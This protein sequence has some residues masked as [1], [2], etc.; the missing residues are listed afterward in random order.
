MRKNLTLEDLGDLLDL[1][2][3]AIL[4]THRKD[5]RILLSPV[6]HEWVDGVCHITTWANDIKSRNIQRDPR[7]TVLITENDPPYRSVEISGE[8]NIE[9]LPDHMPTVRRL[10]AKYIGPEEGDAYAET[11]REQ[12]IELVKIAPGVIRA[13]DFDE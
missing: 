12:K 8:A 2:I 6:W 11:F 7:I 10:A 4:A 3:L 9:P 1:P 13:W 5:G